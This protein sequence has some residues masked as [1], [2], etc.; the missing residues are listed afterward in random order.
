ME[1]SSPKRMV[2]AAD[3]FNLRLLEIDHSVHDTLEINTSRCTYAE[4]FTLILLASQLAS[5][6]PKHNNLK[7][8]LRYNRNS[9][10]FRWAAHLGYWQLIGFP[11]G[12]PV[13]MP[14]PRSNNYIPVQSISIAELRT[15]AGNAPVGPVV[16]TMAERLAATLCG[17]QSQQL[18]NLFAY[19]FR[20]IMRNAAEHSGGDRIT[21]MGQVWPV[22]KETEIV[23]CDDG[24]GIAETLYDNDYIDCTTNFDALKF[25][26]LPGISRASLEERRSEDTWGNSGFGLY[27][28]SR[29]C[30]NKGIFRMIS[31]NDGLTLSNGLQTHHKSWKQKGTLVHMRIKHE[32]GLAQ[33]LKFDEIHEEGKQEFLEKIVSDFPISASKAS[34][35]LSSDF[36]KSENY[37]L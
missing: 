10:F 1:I 13:N 22:I 14:Q 5:I 17:G 18:H 16:Q 3:I 23:V 35:M 27:F 33:L 21:V 25:A 4:P 6:R 28:T 37:Q 12:N 29:F 34:Q 7:L 8:G 31:G 24:V 26:L 19:C 15:T 36:K 9:D 32:D 30:G 20:E 11:C 2:I